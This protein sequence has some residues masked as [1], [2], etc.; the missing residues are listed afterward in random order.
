MRAQHIR[1]SG[2][3]KISHLFDYQ[4]KLCLEKTGRSNGGTMKGRKESNE[5]QRPT[6]NRDCRWLWGWL[7]LC[8]ELQAIVGG[9]PVG[10]NAEPCVKR[11]P[12]P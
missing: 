9:F 6:G 5:T 12:D 8:V 3:D 7:V 10:P 1:A 11:E 2:G 4:A